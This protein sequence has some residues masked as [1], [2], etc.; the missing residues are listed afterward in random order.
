[1]NYRLTFSIT[2]CGKKYGARFTF[3]QVAG[4]DTTISQVSQLLVMVI[5]GMEFQGYVSD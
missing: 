2:G 4:K 3:A 1:M 5:Q